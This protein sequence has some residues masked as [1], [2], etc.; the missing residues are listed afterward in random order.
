MLFLRPSSLFSSAE[1]GR[2]RL[3]LLM[4]STVFLIANGRSLPTK[5][6]LSKMLSDLNGVKSFVS[7]AGSVSP[8]VRFV[9]TDKFGGLEK[10]RERN[11]QT[12]PFL[13]N[14]YQRNC[15]FSPVQCMLSF[16]D[17]TMGEWPFEQMN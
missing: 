11:G 6:K 10:R 7:S 2:F 15:F 5:G 8:M 14:K 4:S 12:Q 13:A 16:Q 3:F 9:G 17:G 1:N